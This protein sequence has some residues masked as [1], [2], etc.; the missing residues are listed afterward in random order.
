MDVMYLLKTRFAHIEL[1]YILVALASFC[2]MQPT[3]A[4]VI[5]INQTI[6]LLDSQIYDCGGGAYP[7]G[8]NCWAYNWD[9]DSTEVDILNDTL[10]FQLNFNN[11]QKIRWQTDSISVPVY[12]D[13]SVQVGA[14]GS[15]G[16]CS[17]VTFHNSL[18][19]LGV[20]GELNHNSIEWEFTGGTGSIVSHSF[21]S[22]LTNL[23]NS[24][25]EFDGLVSTIGPFNNT[26]YQPTTIDRATIFLNSGYFSYTESSDTSTTPTVP[27]PSPFIL[28][29]LGIVM[30][31]MK[32]LRVE[33]K[34]D[35][36][37]SQ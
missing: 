1:L 33:N 4:K 31:F 36:K 7:T 12:G 5:H 9:I 8:T 27:E 14:S 24:W 6:D 19:F 26:Y 17:N 13:E 20:N 21:L 34:I 16:C 18:E 35:M 2:L 30:C 28:V 29:S 23:T 10:V 37:I 25:F 15:G 3:A 32:K 11:S 22:G